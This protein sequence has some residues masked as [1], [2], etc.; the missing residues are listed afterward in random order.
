MKRKGFH[1][2]DARFPFVSRIGFADTEKGAK[3]RL[4]V[5]NPRTGM[6]HLYGDFES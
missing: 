1:R 2:Q 4:V 3:K 6:R 5:S